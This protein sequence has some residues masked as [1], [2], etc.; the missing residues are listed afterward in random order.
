MG[1][2]VT[3]IIYVALSLFIFLS[4][5]P[6]RKDSATLSR[7]LLPMLDQ[8]TEIQ[9]S[10]AMEGYMTQEYSNSI[11]AE[12]WVEALT[13]NADVVKYLNLLEENV[14]YSPVLQTPAVSE[15]LGGLRRNYQAFRDLAELLPSRLQV[16][17]SSLESVTF[18]HEKFS[19][20][21]GEA[22]AQEEGGYRADSGRLARLRKLESMGNSLVVGAVRARHEGGSDE[23]AQAYDIAGQG[24]RLADEL[25]AGAG[26]AQAKEAAAQI[27]ALWGE[28]E[29][30]LKSLEE[31]LNTAEAESVKR[32]Q[33]ASAAIKNASDL[34]LAADRESQRMARDSTATLERVIWS[35]AIGVLVVLLLSTVLA[36]TITRGITR[37][38][39]HLIS[40]LSGGALEVDR[41]AGELSRA[42]NEL[43]AGARNNAASLQDV[44]SALEE[45]SSMTER[46]SGNSL[47][48][49][50]LM[51]QVTG[52]VE[53]ADQSMGKVIRAMEEISASGNEIAKIIKTIDDIAFQTNLLALNAAVEAARAGEAGSGFAVVADEVRNLA[54][55]SAEAAKNTAGLIDSTIGNIKSGSEMVGLTAEN[56]ETVGSH[57]A[58]VAQLLRE[59]AEASREQS[60]GIGQINQSMQTM[61][62]ITQSNA[63]AANESARAAGSLSSQA[64]G[65]LTAV[66]GLSGLVHGGQ[67]LPPVPNS[68]RRLSLPRRA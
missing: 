43:D 53:R 3:N 38:I 11:K 60:Q 20:V 65:L 67:G 2:V 56:F 63:S 27:K 52:A 68:S 5:Q 61:D 37:P 18:G 36:L 4:A 29:G 33:L 49:N 57:A 51:T 12:I 16:I 26:G 62:G 44:S 55:R 42:A 64:A 35:L 25:A 58:K 6:V 41:A 17:N 59:V 9:Y 31:N 8:A 39:N 46:N 34:R 30:G 10:T 45:L 14:K 66:D 1:F 15:A 54:N 50:E 32:G 7:D 23:F 40:D 47:E 24:Y 22:L 19:A 13:Y 48:A 28:M 21:I